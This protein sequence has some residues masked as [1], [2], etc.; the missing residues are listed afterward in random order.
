[1]L[2]ILLPDI[3]NELGLSDSEIGFISGIAFSLFYALMGIPIARLADRYSRRVIVSTAMA[4]WSA[5]TAICGLAQSFWQLA[6]ARI[7]VGVGEAG[8][9]PPSHSL[10]SDL[11]PKDRRAF[12]LAIYALGSPLGIFLGFLLGGWLTQEFGWRVALFSFG[13]PG[14]ILAF[15]VF[16]KLPEPKRGAAD[17]VAA[18]GLTIPLVA[19]LKTLFSRPTYI[20]NC[21]GSGLY[22][23]V[24]L[25]LINWTPSYFERNHEMSIAAIGVWLAF[26]GGGAQLAGVLAGGWLADRLSARSLSWLMRLC[27]LAVFVAIP[28]YAAAVMAPTPELGFALL[29]VPFISSTLQAGPQHATTQ[30]VSPVAM[31]ATAAATYLLIVNLLGGVGTQLMGLLS[32][33]LNKDYG[34]MALGWAIVIVATFFSLWSALHFALA[35][36]TLERDMARAD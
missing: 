30:G 2:A 4:V 32:D 20:H 3:K 7:M 31:R 10:I 17:S 1:M 28:F 35:S 25:G 15:V 6:I 12:A 16:L 5:M 33:Y 11:Y 24:Y 18:D 22:T 14:L 27:G 29:I 8:A 26:V 36:R 34:D 9:T 21:V 19:V 13:V 23:M